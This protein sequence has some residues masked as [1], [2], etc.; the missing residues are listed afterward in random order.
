MYRG[1]KMMKMWKCQVLCLALLLGSHT[2]L[3]A[4]GDR[5]RAEQDRIIT[6]LKA[7]EFQPSLKIWN[8]MGLER[9]NKTLAEIS[10][11]SGAEPRL[12]RRAILALGDIPSDRTFVT[13]R[14]VLGSRQ[15]SLGLKRQALV[16]F[17]HAFPK[18]SFEQVH[19][20]LLG[21]SKFMREAAALALTYVQDVRVDTL[22]L[23]RISLDS[24]MVVRTAL[25]RTK[26][27]RLRMKSKPSSKTYRAPSISPLTPAQRDGL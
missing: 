11:A 1:Q 6:I 27:M 24:E 7:Y 8:E 14:A 9:V 23:E 10:L 3:F 16:S 5:D 2:S 19:Q 13:L 22:V 4:A 21:K 15:S 25:E 26:E 12:R 17:A 18:K 20:E